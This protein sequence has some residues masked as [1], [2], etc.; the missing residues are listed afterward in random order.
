MV[1]VHVLPVALHTSDAAHASHGDGLAAPWP[2]VLV[3]A[4]ALLLYLLQNLVLPGRAASD[5]HVSVGWGFL[6]GLSVHAFATGLGVAAA[7]GRPSLAGALLL[8]VVMHKAA[9]GFSVATVFLLSGKGRGKIL[10]LVAL[11]ALTTPAGLLA[12]EAL[13]GQLGPAG[14]DAFVAL[15]AGTFLFVALGDLLPEVFHGRHD[16]AWRVVLL[17]TGVALGPLLHID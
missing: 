2:G 10:L 5:P 6:V 7:S 9:E 14:R 3:L 12:G 8:P 17:A 1:F 4:G 16:T 11:F 15:A 13:R